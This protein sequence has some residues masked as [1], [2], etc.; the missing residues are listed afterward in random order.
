MKKLI[1]HNNNTFLSDPI[2]FE[3][4][5]QFVFEFDKDNSEIDKIIHQQIICGELYNKI[6]NADLLFIKISLSK[7]YLEYLGL[8]LAYHIRLT[9]KL[10]EKSRVPI[11]FVA[12]ESI[13]FIGI[14][15]SMPSLLH[16]KGVYFMKDNENAFRKVLDMMTSNK[17]KRSEDIVEL[18]KRLI[19]PSPSNYSSHH[20][21]ENELALLS[22]SQFIGCYNRLPL[23]KF[24]FLNTLYYKLN[25][26]EIKESESQ[27]YIMTIEE[28][29]KI[30]LID[31]EA[32]KGW[33]LF[34]NELF[35]RTGKIEFFESNVSFTHRTKSEII[36]DLKNRISQVSPDLVLLDIRL[37]E[38]DF[39][40]N[41]PPNQL[42]GYLIAQIIK[43]LNEGIQIVITTASNKIWNFSVFE[44]FGSIDHLLKSNSL[45]LKKQFNDFAVLINRKLKQSHLLKSVYSRIKFTINQLTELSSQ[46]DFD[47]EFIEKTRNHLETSFALLEKS[48]HDTVY[49]NHAYLQLY[50]ILEDFASSKA[51]F[52]EKGEECLVVIDNKTQ[53]VVLIKNEIKSNN[54]VVYESP[55]VREKHK[56]ILKRGKTNP[57]FGRLNMD[58]KMHLIL[59]FRYG[60][61][62]Q[63]INNWVSLNKVRNSKAGHSGT[64]SLVSQTD[65]YLIL[66]FIQFI[67]ESKSINSLHKNKSLRVTPEEQQNALLEKFNTNKKRKN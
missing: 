10:G 18:K 17:L 35:K 36:E 2:Y 16:T 46:N 61:D 19:L 5:D 26:A 45:D 28:S 8:R 59:F 52:I 51:V 1:I 34:Y 32:T 65:L 60:G 56:Y 49:R 50:F 40:E 27:E 55:I 41:L 43:E 33:N 58:F 64:N 66:D 57:I 9:T 37:C 54:S 30:M 62:N 44:K 3:I 7:N 25:K 14:T 48:I 39:D 20:S 29:G 24:D 53:I 23:D 42:S 11:V 4:E 67:F 31:D 13:Q 47:N 22:W 63:I 6:I 12:E 38:A 21:I 15:S